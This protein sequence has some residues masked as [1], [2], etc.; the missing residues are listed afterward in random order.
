[1]ASKSLVD[2][3]VFDLGGTVCDGIDE[4]TGLANI[5]PINAL[6][7]SLKRVWDI[8]PPFDV[9]LPHMATRK[10]DHLFKILQTPSIAAEFKE[11]HG[12][13]PVFADAEFCFNSAF[14][15]ILEID[16]MPKRS[17]PFDGVIDMFKDLKSKD[18]KIGIDTGFYAKA[19][20]IILGKFGH[21]HL[22]DADIGADE[23][24]QARPWPFMM[25]K[26]MDELEII[27]VRRTMKVGDV[28]PTDFLEGYNTGGISVGLTECGN[29]RPA[30][31]WKDFETSDGREIRAVDWFSTSLE[32]KDKMFRGWLREAADNGTRV[33]YPMVLI[34][35]SN[36]LTQL[37]NEMEQIAPV[38]TS[39]L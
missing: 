11:K 16:E 32:E 21:N 17:E 14:K 4:E 29:T 9:I 39:L 37:I 26:L 30:S 15:E 8:D 20:R 10:L 13:E 35:H 31:A 25:F 5:G 38:F 18:I 6:R 27:D 36:Q 3:V 24:S 7:F 2:M 1:M 34:P 23:V 22:I 19:V 12:R 33:P 28:Y